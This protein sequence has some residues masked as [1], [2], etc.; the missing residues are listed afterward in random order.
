MSSAAS[1]WLLTIDDCF[2]LAHGAM[3]GTEHDD[4]NQ[5]LLIHQL[6][7]RYLG[8]TSRRGGSSHPANRQKEPSP[9]GGLGSEPAKI[10]MFM[11]ILFVFCQKAV[12]RSKRSLINYTKKPK[13]LF[14]T[15]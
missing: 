8:R 11:V 14:A 15:L 1:G 6:V 3:T 12:I 13:K 7:C 2:N 9:T 5:Q 10:F 4:F